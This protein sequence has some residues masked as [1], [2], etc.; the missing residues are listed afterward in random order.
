M[1]NDIALKKMK[2]DKTNNKNLLVVNKDMPE[3]E[4]ITELAQLNGFIDEYC[5]IRRKLLE[6][7]HLI[8]R[9]LQLPKDNI[10]LSVMAM[11]SQPI[12][13]A[14]NVLEYYKDNF[15]KFEDELWDRINVEEGMVLLN[16][17]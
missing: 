16:Q 12:E 14:I 11:I 4:E 10:P 6:N 1:I 3:K 7:L 17:Q 15:E 5:L 8:N 2:N 13:I 9:D